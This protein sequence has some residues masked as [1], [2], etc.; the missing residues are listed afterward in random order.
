MFMVLFD[1]GCDPLRET[2]REITETTDTATLLWI[3]DDHWKFAD[4]SR[5]WAEC[6]DWIVTT[7][8]DAIPNYRAL[9]LGDRAILSQWA[10]N[11]RLYR[12]S[13]EKRD[14]DVSFVGQP[15][16]DRAQI[17]EGLR[18]EGIDV[19]VFGF[20]WG[21]AGH[22]LP[23]REMVRTFNRSRINLNLANPL[24][25]SCPQIKGRNFEVPGCK[26]FLL[27][28]RVPDLDHYFQPAVEVGVFG[29]QQDLV[30]KVRFYLENEDQRNRIAARGYARCLRE[31]TWDHRLHAL[32]DRIGLWTGSAK[33]LAPAEAS[34]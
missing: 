18:R 14:I 5:P 11:H 21:D 8:H 19:K 30:Q 10:V 23:F 32:F 1:E 26:G 16:S 33:R 29:D 15:H 31:H 24:V 9:G 25:G 6:L 3:C 2:V 27:T 13:A 28:D 7:D 34:D 22:R 20:G 17:I 4:Y 12:P